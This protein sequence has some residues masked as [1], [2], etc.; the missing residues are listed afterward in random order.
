MKK[1]ENIENKRKKNN[2]NWLIP[3]VIALF[4]LTITAYTLLKGS[5]E[6]DFVLEQDCYETLR[7]ALT[8]EEILISD[9]NAFEKEVD[10]ISNIG[11]LGN[12]V[13]TRTVSTLNNEMISAYYYNDIDTFQF[14]FYQI[15]SKSF[16]K[17][18]SDFNKKCVTSKSGNSYYMLAGIDS[19]ETGE[20]HY[21]TLLFTGGEGLI[22]PKIDMTCT[23]YI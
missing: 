4:V 19:D 12:S 3:L 18:F 23:E 11:N 1:V 14:C 17:D 13:R 5:S 20:Y 10:D 8:K 2:K 16:S 9:Y 22:N 15:N 6:N 7:D 21:L